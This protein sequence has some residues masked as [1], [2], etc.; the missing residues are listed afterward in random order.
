MHRRGELPP[1]GDTELRVDPD[2]MRFDRSA[3]DE[4]ALTDL[5][6]GE[7]LGDELDHGS[8]GV[9]D[10]LPTVARPAGGPPRSNVQTSLAEIEAESAVEQRGPEQ[11][12]LVER[13]IGE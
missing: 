2:Q 7:S 8:L 6:V 9:P 4:Q 1:I 3:G 5:G 13:A 10:R 11:V 12:V